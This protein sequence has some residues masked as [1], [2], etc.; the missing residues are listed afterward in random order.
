MPLPHL[1]IPTA[2]RL[3]VNLTGS[4]VPHATSGYRDWQGHFGS[5]EPVVAL[6]VVVTDN[7]ASWARSTHRGCE[8]LETRI[9]FSPWDEHGRHI[10][11]SFSILDA[12]GFGDTFVDSIQT[13][14]APVL[15]PFETGTL[16]RIAT[17][18]TSPLCELMA[19]FLA[20]RDVVS[21]RNGVWHARG[22]VVSSLSEPWR[23]IL[24]YGRSGE[25]DAA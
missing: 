13:Q 7:N 5:S 25:L 17:V 1:V 8:S 12:T 24:T 20:R 22:N 21:V 10:R 14:P 9:L 15:R 19:I 16:M 23:K 4:P 3:T 18:T 11:V 6:V 2:T